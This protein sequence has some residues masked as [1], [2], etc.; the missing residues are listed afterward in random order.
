MCQVCMAD[1]GTPSFRIVQLQA[2]YDRGM[3]IEE[4]LVFSIPHSVFFIHSAYSPHVLPSPLG[5]ILVCPSIGGTC[6]ALHRC[7]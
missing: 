4:F 7:R 1:D 6:P 3:R 2:S 5:A